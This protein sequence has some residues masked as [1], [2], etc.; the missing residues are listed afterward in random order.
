MTPE[1]INQFPILKRK[2]NNKA[3]V[4]L[5][6]AATTQKPERVINRIVELYR[7]DNSN[8]HRG[9][10]TLSERTSC[11]YDEA[12]SLVR[13]FINASNE[14]E[15]IF[16]S[17]TTASINLVASSFGQEFI[18]AGDTIITTEMEHHSNI[19]PWQL[20][21]QRKKATLRTVPFDEQGN[22]QLHTLRNLLTDNTKLVAVTWVSNSVGTVNPIR[23]IIKI[24]HEAGI[25]VL[26]D[27]AQAA[28]H[29]P[30][31]VQ[32]LDCDFLVFSGHKM[33]ADTG[34]GILYGKEHWLE[35]M[36]PW[37]S[38]GGMINSVTLKETTFDGLPFKFEAGTPNYA[39]A[40]SL[41]EAVKFLQNISMDK[42]QTFEQALSHQ[43]REKMESL[44]G[45]TVYGSHNSGIL[46]F[47]LDNIHHYDAGMLLDKLGIAVR[48]GA[49]CAEPAMRSL[50]VSGTIRASLALY[51]TEDDID[52]LISG[53]KRV[54]SLLG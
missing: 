2:I 9:V 37:Q 45:V 50:A 35:K 13:G 19:I 36:P 29:R 10:H 43:A 1:I 11:Y 42:I 46:S 52:K 21:C 25:P 53:T 16:T 20:L 48:T 14:R 6:N 15:I 12:R 47:N 40:I 49:H 39:G 31:N 30:I 54:Q 4:Y 51:N 22:L 18:S 27:A 28:S 34:I 38:G 26:I 8:I 23:K 7:K 3:L 17:G 33:Y 5:D 41:G 44:D 32:E 24:A